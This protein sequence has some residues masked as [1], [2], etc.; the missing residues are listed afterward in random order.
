MKTVVKQA[1]YILRQISEETKHDT[2]DADEGSSENKQ[3]K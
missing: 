2:R 3:L 1:N